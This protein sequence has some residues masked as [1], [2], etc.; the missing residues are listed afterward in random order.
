MDFDDLF[1]FW[2]AA[3]RHDVLG[4][5]GR[6]LDHILVDEF[7]DVNQLQLD[8]LWGCA[9]RPARDPGGRR[10]ASDLRFSRRVATLPLERGALLRGLT[11]ITLELNYR[12]SAAVLA[13]ANALAADAPE[14]FGAVL[15]ESTARPRAVQPRSCTARTNAP[16]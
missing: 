9:S 10:R 11:T 7:Q 3:V 6:A 14:G 8:V 13:V 1:F 16:E 2:R 5:T 4:E 12:S 15:R